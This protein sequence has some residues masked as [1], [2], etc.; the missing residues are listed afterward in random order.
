MTRSLSSLYQVE[1]TVYQMVS[2]TSLVLKGSAR[3]SSDQTAPLS[4]IRLHG[5]INMFT[6][7]MHLFGIKLQ[8]NPYSDPTGHVAQSVTCLTADPGVASLIP[9]RSHTY[10]EID[11]EKFIWWFASLPLIHSRRVVVCY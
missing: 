3:L 4:F 10:V 7:L 6:L 1:S 11:D 9:A 8:I 2:S 5:K